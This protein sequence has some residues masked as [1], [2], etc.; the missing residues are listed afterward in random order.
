MSKEGGRSSSIQDPTVKESIEKKNLLSFT[1]ENVNV[2]IANALRRTVLSDIK[3]VVINPEENDNII[4]EKNTTRFNNE[5]L[6]QR[7]GCIPIHIKDLDTIEDLLVEIDETNE[8]DSLEYITTKNFKIKNGKSGKYLE[9]SVVKKIFPP[10]KLTEC[11]ILFTRLRPKI[12]NDIPGESIQLQAKLS[13]GTAK[14]EGMFNVAS[15]C[16]YGNTPDQVAQNARWT[17]ISE[18]LEKKNVSGKEITYQRQDWYTLAAKRLYIPD[19]FDFKVESVGVFT[20]MELIHMACDIIIKK[21]NNIVTKCDDSDIPLIKTTTAMENC[22]DVKLI[23]ENY[24]IGKV[25]EYILHEDYYLH[26]NELTYI[27]FIKKHPHD[28]HSI[29]RLAFKE[30]KEF[31]DNNIYALV[32]FAAL[33]GIHIFKIIKEYF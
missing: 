15:T 8:K 25:L 2:S 6:K 20:N 17:E 23:N 31:T 3:T 32:K 30:K 14:E 7:L 22:V 12:S 4:I 24:T 28:N 9:E 33:T 26:G 1:L 19:S 21:L 29:I 13:I 27:G 5:I 10:N 16:A 11:Y 18:A